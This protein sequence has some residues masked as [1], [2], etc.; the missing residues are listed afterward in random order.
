MILMTSKIT[1]YSNLRTSF[2]VLCAVFLAIGIIYGV[3]VRIV[4]I[5]QKYFGFE[6]RREIA[7]RQ[8]RGYVAGET[9]AKMR[10]IQHDMG[11]AGGRS[12]GPL[13]RKYIDVSQVKTGKIPRSKR[14]QPSRKLQPEEG[15]VALSGGAD[16]TTVLGTGADETTVLGTGVDETTVLGTGADETTVLGTGVDETTVLGT[17]AD[18]TTVLQ[19]PEGTVVLS[20][21]ERVRIEKKNDIM[22]VHGDDII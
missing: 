5:I 3:R 8:S 21:K 1:L 9:T 14:L 18:E 16:E 4:S 11:R 20:P 7:R 22:V 13:D 17:G 19:E 6:K 10:V 12:S 2:F 15:T